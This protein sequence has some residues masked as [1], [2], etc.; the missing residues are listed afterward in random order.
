MD[1]RSCLAADEQLRLWKVQN[2]ISDSLTF[3]RVSPHF[4]M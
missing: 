1:S 2:T 3:S 4:I